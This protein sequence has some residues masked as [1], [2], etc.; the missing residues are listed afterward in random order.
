M[1]GDLR[2]VAVA[3]R[4]YIDAIPEE[5]ADKFPAMPGVDRDWVDEVIDAAPEVKELRPGFFQVKVN[6][7]E[8]CPDCGSHSMEIETSSEQDDFYNCGDQVNCS[9][10]EKLGEIMVDDNCA[11]IEWSETDA[12]Q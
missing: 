8:P 7:D 9:R 10:C 11:Y 6:W 4:D 12:G 2:N 1:R 3:L 5:L